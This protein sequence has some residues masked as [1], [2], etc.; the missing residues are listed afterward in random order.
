MGLNSNR[1]QRP[2]VKG[3][4]A[5]SAVELV[6]RAGPTADV[7]LH[8]RRL[9]GRRTRQLREALSNAIYVELVLGDATVREHRNDVQPPV[10][11]H[12]RHRHSIDVAVARVEAEPGSRQQP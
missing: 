7:G 2:V 9:R 1:A 3:N 5:K 4:L 10:G 6:T 8:R 11:R 12:R